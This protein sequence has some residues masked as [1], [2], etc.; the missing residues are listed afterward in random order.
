M[1]GNRNISAADVIRLSG[2]RKGQS[3]LTLSE[4]ETERRLINAATSAAVEQATTPTTSFSSV[5]WRRSC[6]ER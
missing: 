4:K 5:T 3:I 2:I 1:T 6:P